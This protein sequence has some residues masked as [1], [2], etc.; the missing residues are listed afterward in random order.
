V[1][2]QLLPR[3]PVRQPRQ[4]VR[5]GE[6]A[7]LSDEHVHAAGQVQHADAEAGGDHGEQQA[8]VPCAGRVV[9]GADQQ[10]RAQEDRGDA[11]DGNRELS[12]SCA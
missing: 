4:L 1:L 8:C 6:L 11:G 5:A 10:R 3:P 2:E 12:A 7:E 9:R